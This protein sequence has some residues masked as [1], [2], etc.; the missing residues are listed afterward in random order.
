MTSKESLEFST[1]F[2]PAILYTFYILPL[3]FY[4]YSVIVFITLFSRT[5]LLYTCFIHLSGPWVRD[6]V[7]FFFK[8][9]TV[10]SRMPYTSK[11]RLWGQVYPVPL[12][13]SD[14]K[15]HPFLTLAQKYRESTDSLWFCVIPSTVYLQAVITDLD[16]WLE[17]VIKLLNIQ[18]LL[19][20]SKL[21]SFS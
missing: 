5:Q 4:L 18:E 12:L 13:A 16:E 7:S 11:H 8:I 6:F 2:P 14:G 9:L 3:G 20:G 1:K 17:M 19:I 15:T 10:H 21:L